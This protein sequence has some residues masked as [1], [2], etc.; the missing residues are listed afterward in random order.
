MRVL[1]AYD[2]SDCSEEAF[3]DLGMAGLPDEV[4][5]LILTAANVWL[6]PALAAGI[7]PAVKITT[8][9]VERALNEAS[10]KVDEARAIADRGAETLRKLFPLWRVSAEAVADSPAWAVIKRA[11]E[12]DADLVVVGANG[13]S[14]ISR[15]ERLALGSTS[16]KIVTEAAC[17]V[18]VARSRERDVNRPIRLVIGLDGSDDSDRAIR[19]VAGRQWPTGT[20]VLLLTAID[21]RLMTTIFEPPAQLLAWIEE[22]DEDPLNWVGRMLADYRHQLESSG[23]KVKTIVN[24]GDPKSLLLDEATN[25]EAD[26]IVLGARGH[27]LIERFLIGSVSTSITSRATCS[28]EVVR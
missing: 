18:R 9:A 26:C 7:D 12:W 21:D 2:G 11:R 28:V 15:L 5:A 4:D 25:W 10:A 27:N 6:P 23:L 3:K 8:V 1:I 16:Q 14:D 19:T 17:T 20:E 24:H 22:T 13:A